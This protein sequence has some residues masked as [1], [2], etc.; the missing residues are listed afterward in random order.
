MTKIEISCV[1]L[2]EISKHV[3]FLQFD[4]EHYN[5]N[6]YDSA[7]RATIKIDCKN[8]S[9]IYSLSE[10]FIN[11]SSSNML[12]FTECESVIIPPSWVELEAICGDWSISSEFGW[13]ICMN[14]DDLDFIEE[15]DELNEEL[16]NLILK[17]IDNKMLYKIISEIL[18]KI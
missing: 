14:E 18:T 7:P 15:E 12:K 13:E 11:S 8:N 10:N 6:E 9:L 1:N 16:K 5:D 3:N 4:F 2:N 17:T